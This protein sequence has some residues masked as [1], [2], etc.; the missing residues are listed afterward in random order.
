M[1][2]A[3]LVPETRQG[4]SRAPNDRNNWR[5]HG[6]KAFNAGR[7]LNYMNYV[8]QVRLF[9]FTVNLGENRQKLEE[10]GRRD[11]TFNAAA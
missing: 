9:F 6:G 1:L 5:S 2:L 10:V 8:G 4:P 3:R 7:P 11:D